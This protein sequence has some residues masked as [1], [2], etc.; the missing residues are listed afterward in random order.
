M[1]FLQPA[2]SLMQRLRLLPKFALVS[3]VFL[4]PLLLAS[5]LLVAELHKSVSYT[6][7]ERQG[8]AYLRQLHEVRRQLQQKRSL[9]HMRLA[10][11]QQ[12]AARGSVAASEAESAALAQL[13]KLAVG[14]LASLPAQ[15]ELEQGWQQLQQRQASLDARA[16]FAA[17]SK[18]LA[19]ADALAALA[20]DRARL[21]LDPEVRSVYLIASFL[22]TFPGL[23]ENLSVIAGRGAA[24]IDSGLF[25]ANEDQMLTATSMLARHE[26]ERLPAQYDAIFANNP[27]LAATLQP[28][29]AAVPAAL[30]FLER[31][32]NE[33]LNSYNQSSGKE[34]NAAGLQAIAALETLSS[35]TAD[36]LDQLLAERAAQD[37]LRRNGVA[38]V[39]LLAIA[40]ASWLG[41]GFYASFNRDIRQLNRAVRAAAAGDLSARIASPARDEIGSL[42][43]AFSSM[44]AAL[45]TLITDIRSGAARIAS[46]ADELASG[47]TALNG[48]TST[49]AEALHITVNAMEE[50]DAAVQRNSAHADDGRQLVQ[51][52]AGVARKG[53]A[54]VGAVVDTMAAIRSSSDRIAD[55]IG[56]ID[57]I[58]FQTNILALNAAVEAARAGN[59]GRGFAV[60]ATEVRS[61]AQRSA[62]AALEIKHLIGD[63]VDKVESGNAQVDAAGA[64]MQQVVASVR[65]MEEVIARITDAEAGQRSEIAR[66]NS[67]LHRIDD[68]TRQN[69]ALVVQASEG[70]S[71][72][73]AETAMLNEALGQFRLKKGDVPL[74]GA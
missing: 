59:H 34:F 25:E 26:L 14:P 5:G 44:T 33:V 48:S 54:S 22:K 47:S 66:I 2:I 16:S 63:S 9:E 58:A 55:I 46:A 64:T 30:A 29:M 70:A 73:H 40:L 15:T 72:V 32:R 67:A 37:T 20:A 18:L 50:L 56:V 49:Q 45:E 61:L 7:Q 60:V 13:R 27:G 21:S 8:L 42:A 17:H 51:H 57:G 68:M 43:N 69:A 24:Y 35:Q 39:V 36:A 23:T 52:A 4:L 11:S 1:I 41:A 12:E 3:L 65:S 28:R 19:Q 38:A 62:A 31:A 10:A 71:R 74:L 6:A 53:G